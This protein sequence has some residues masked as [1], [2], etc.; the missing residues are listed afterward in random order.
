MM[1]FIDR[2]SELT[3]FSK[4]IVTWA[5]GEEGQQYSHDKKA[6]QTTTFV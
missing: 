3:S 2:N 4:P 6:T 1:T 5:G